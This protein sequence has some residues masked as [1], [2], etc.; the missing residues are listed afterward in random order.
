MMLREGW[1]RAQRNDYRA[2]AP[3]LGQ[4]GYP[5]GADPGA[6]ATGMFPL[7]DLPEIVTVI[8]HPAF[9]SCTKTNWPRRAWIRR[10]SRPEA[11][12][13]TVTIYVDREHKPVEPLEI[14]VP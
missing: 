13:Q 5:A 11:F 4:I 7:S 10:P 2:V 14:E 3:L 9:R 12:K 1:G 8:E 6:R